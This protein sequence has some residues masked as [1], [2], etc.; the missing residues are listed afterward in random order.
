VPGYAGAETPISNTPLS[1]SSHEVQRLTQA[2]LDESV[3]LAYITNSPGTF[4]LSPDN[5]IHLKNLGLSSTAISA[6]I[7]HDQDLASSSLRMTGQAGTEPASLVTP[8]DPPGHA[9]ILAN[10]EAWA[11]GALFLNEDDY[12]PEQPEDIGPVRAPYPVK[13]SD[14]IIIFKLP[15]FRLQYW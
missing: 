11:S 8:L 7:L 15:S 14:P 1:A 10:D 12:A 13:L 3:I 4:D 6:M 9:P 2:G 5:I